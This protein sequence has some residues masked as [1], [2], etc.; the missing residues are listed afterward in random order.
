MIFTDTN[1]AEDLSKVA[2]ENRSSQP[3]KSKYICP[4]EANFEH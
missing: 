1:F 3:A 4:K 2:S